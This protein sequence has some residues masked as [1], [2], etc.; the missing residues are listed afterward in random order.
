MRSLGGLVLLAGLGVGLFVYLPAPVDRDTSLKNAQQHSEMSTV[1]KQRAERPVAAPATQ[2]GLR[3]FSPGISLA[4]IAQRNVPSVTRPDPAGGWRT[5]SASDPESRSLEP[6]SPESR[7][8][9][10]VDI[11]QQLKRVGCYWGRADGSWGS[12]TKYAMQSFMTRVNAALPY[13]EPDY[14]LLTLLKS[15]SGE[16]CGACPA[17]QVLLPGG[18]CVP[19]TTVA[20]GQPNPD[21]TA[22]IAAKE[23]LPWQAPG[24][25]PNKP[26]F[27]PLPNSVVSTEPLPGRMAIGGPAAL[28][29]V[30][31]VYAPPA[32]AATDAGQPDA[33]TAAA[34]PVVS[35]PAPSRPTKTY[36]KR[37]RY[38]GPGTP[39]HNLMLSLGGV[40]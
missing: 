40:Y 1:P 32:V 35:S 19:Q 29:P 21:A 2:P 9:L 36:K 26:L 12:G 15:H 7:Y 3:S 39:R 23:T 37:R 30:N 20:Y 8:R 10:V 6:T 24:A 27:T 17:D 18:R 13:D 31:S 33:T 11:Q 5:T 16:V 38:D 34:A 25:A 14:V 22:A 28:P 4:A